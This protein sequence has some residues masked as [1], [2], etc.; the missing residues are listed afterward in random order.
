[1][2]MIDYLDNLTFTEEDI[3]YLRGKN[4]FCEEF[5][6]YLKV[7]YTFEY[8]YMCDCKLTWEDQTVW[9]IMPDSFAQSIEDIRGNPIIMTHLLSICQKHEP[10]LIH[11]NV[12]TQQDFD[13]QGTSTPGDVS[14]GQPD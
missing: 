7:D 1:M 12:T 10:S 6:D 14:S 2:K 4:I 13:R 9:C 3:D 11:V 8:M 5:L